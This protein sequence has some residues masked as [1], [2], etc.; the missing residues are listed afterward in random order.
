MTGCVLTVFSSSSAGPSRT[1]FHKSMPNALLATSNVARTPGSVSN[2]A[3]IPT[4]CEPCPGK[5]NANVMTCSS[6]PT[7]QSRTPGEAAAHGLEHDVL[8]RLNASVAHRLIQRQRY[9][10]GRSIGVAIDRHD[11]AI[12]AQAELARGGFDDAQ[13]GLVRDQPI[14][15][16]F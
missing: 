10:S 8:A 5:A 13:V 6:Y 11:H 9:R 14:D 2:G 12:H 3:I 16:G 1:R 4:D 7:Q 15:G